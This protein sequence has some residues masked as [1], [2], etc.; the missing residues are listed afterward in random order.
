MTNGSKEL[1]QILLQ[2]LQLEMKGLSGLHAVLHL[3]NEGFMLCTMI[4]QAKS[5]FNQSV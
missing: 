2:I 1:M 5:L 4:L 3:K